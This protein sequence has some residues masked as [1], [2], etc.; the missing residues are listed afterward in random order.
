MSECTNQELKVLAP[1]LLYVGLS[2]LLVLLFLYNTVL[3]KESVT[4]NPFRLIYSVLKYASKSKHP[5]LRSAF[6]YGKD[7]LPSCIDFGKNKYGGPFT[8]EQVEDMKTFF[9]ILGIIVIAGA[10]ITIKLL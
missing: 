8:T 6:T 1:F 7:D 4:Q 10:L 5:Q 9:K 3:I 2:V